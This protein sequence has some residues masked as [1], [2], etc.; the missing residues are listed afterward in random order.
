ML[1]GKEITIY[2]D[3]RDIRVIYLFLEGKYMGEAYCPKFMGRRVSIWEAD[4]LRKADAA[5]KREAEAEALAGRQRTQR[6]A[7][8]GGRAHRR[9]VL[10]LE[11]QKQMDR[12]QEDIHPEHVQTK[13]KELGQL[14]PPGS[15]PVPTTIAPSALPEPNDELEKRP[16]IY[17]PM[18]RWNE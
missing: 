14:K 4:A 17:L 11:K 6:L 18:R 2:Y 8:R 5:P 7:R 16:I 15:P 3:R 13:L 9:E 10:R 12:Q 1:V